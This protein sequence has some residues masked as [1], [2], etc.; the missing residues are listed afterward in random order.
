VSK[1]KSRKIGYTSIWNALYSPALDK[2]L[3]KMA[4]LADRVFCFCEGQARTHEK[5]DLKR[6]GAQD[7]LG[8]IHEWHWRC[9]VRQV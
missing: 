9:E 4:E 1:A 2:S 6:Q 3:Q 8:H 5:A 7:T